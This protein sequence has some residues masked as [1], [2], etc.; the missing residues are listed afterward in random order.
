MYKNEDFEKYIRLVGIS[1]KV[2]NSY[3]T[4]E[5]IILYFL[6]FRSHR[7]IF[8]RRSCWYSVIPSLDATIS[9]RIKKAVVGRMKTRKN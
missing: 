1:I 6:T 9:C 8:T 7:E 4:T 5:I 3:I 2:E